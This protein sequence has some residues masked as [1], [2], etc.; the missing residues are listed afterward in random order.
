[1]QLPQKELSIDELVR[2][3]SDNGYNVIRF[4]TSRGN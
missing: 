1:M 4:E 3:A 2:D